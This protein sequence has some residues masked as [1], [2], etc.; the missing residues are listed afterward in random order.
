MFKM[1]LEIEALAI[2][3]RAHEAKLRIRLVK[4]SGTRKVVEL[5]HHPWTVVWRQLSF[6]RGSV[7]V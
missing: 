3:L 2:I 1:I 7:V 5:T 6:A 4:T